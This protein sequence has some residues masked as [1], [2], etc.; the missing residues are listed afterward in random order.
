MDF[1]NSIDVDCFDAFGN[2]NDKMYIKDEFIN[3]IVDTVN[4]DIVNDDIVNGDVVNDDVDVEYDVQTAQIIES[5][6]MYIPRNINDIVDIHI[7]TRI[8]LAHIARLTHNKVVSAHNV[9]YATSLFKIQNITELNIK[10]R[11]PKF[12]II[13][14]DIGW[15]WSDKFIDIICTAAR[16]TTN[17]IYIILSIKYNPYI[18]R[19]DV[20]NFRHICNEHQL[21]YAHEIHAGTYINMIDKLRMILLS[22]CCKYGKQLKHNVDIPQ[23]LIHQTMQR[24]LYL[25]GDIYCIDKIDNQ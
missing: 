3:E 18:S 14:P 8:I 24:K 12:I 11:Q 17:K 21:D 4:D 13:T 20:Y 19:R 7:N 23:V 25:F 16:E 10:L 2:S 6:S 5:E 15:I 9:L 22:I 1:L